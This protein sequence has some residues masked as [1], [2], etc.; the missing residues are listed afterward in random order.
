[1]LTQR[2]VVLASR[3]MNPAPH[4]IFVGPMGAGKTSIGKR[5]AERFGLA[6]VDVD[7]YIVEQ[8]GADI[9]TIFEHVGEAGF[10]ERESAALRLLLE[11]QGKLVSTGGGAVLDAGNRQLLRQHGFVVF[12][13]VSVQG[14][15]KRL[16]RCSNRPLLQRPDRE[17]AL[18]RMAELRNP[19]Y[20]EVADL[21]LPT[22]ELTPAAA[23][24][25]LVQLLASRW[26]RNECPA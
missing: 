20:H 13:Q 1:M 12:L 18:A 3:V 6:F 23:T 2:H 24:A 11:G 25:Q 4:L 26:Q 10:R 15:L 22:D 5:I 8:V 21:C 7:Q 16:G 9:P 19:L 14:Q 17:E